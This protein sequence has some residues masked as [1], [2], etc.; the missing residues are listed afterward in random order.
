MAN[1]VK[2]KSPALPIPPAQ[3]NQS[4]YQRTFSILRLYFNQLDEHLRQ[5]LGDTTINGDLTV[6]ADLA[7]IVS[8]D[9]GAAAAPVF[10]LYRNSASP[11]VSDILGSLNFTGNLVS[12]GAKVTYASIDA[13][14]SASLGSNQPK[15]TLR[16][17]TYVNGSQVTLAQLDTQTGLDLGTK[18]L[19]AGYFTIGSDSGYAPNNVINGGLTINNFGSSDNLELVDT[20]PSNVTSDP[21]LSFYRD[22]SSPA[23]NDHAGRIE[24]YANNDA[25]Q[26]TN[27]AGIL[28]RILDVT[29][30]TEDGELSFGVMQAGTFN[31]LLTLDP[32]GVTATGATTVNGALTV[33]ADLLK[34]VSTDAGA[35]ENPILSLYRNSSSIAVS[36]EI[37]AVEFRGNDAEGAEFV[38]G[39][40]YSELSVVG[41]GSEQ[42]NL[43]FALGRAGDIEDPVM[44]LRQYA[45]EMQAGNDIYLSRTS[46]I[47]FEGD[48]T[49]SNET[50][51]YVVDPTADRTILLPDADGTVALTTAPTFT[52]A[53]T[54]NGAFTANNIYSQF[55]SDAMTNYRNGPIVELFANS[56]NTTTSGGA[57][58][59]TGLNEDNRKVSYGSFYMSRSSKLD[60]GEHRGSLVFTVADGS[61]AVDPYDDY[62]NNSFDTGHALALNINVDY[63]ITTGYLKSNVGEL[64]LGDKQSIFDS[65]DV[66]NDQSPYD[67]HMPNAYR[68]KVISIG[69]MGPFDAFVGANQSV[70]QMLQYRGQHMVVA[71]GGA[72]EFELPACAA[73]STISNSTANIGDVWQITNA[74][75]GALTIDRDGSGTAQT[76]Y[77]FPSLTLTAFTN[78]PTLAVGGTMM[79][80]AVAANVW[81][82]FN[83]T[84]LSDA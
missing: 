81:M 70:A 16:F 11:A 72:L 74:A 24:F 27:T 57:F 13:D 52:G 8:T 46:D 71:A 22:S 49:N 1:N 53:T 41:S 4:L 65:A 68:A 23:D 12:G 79:L 34:V 29:D 10:E 31:T 32:N 60:D 33:N 59:F 61:G 30:G 56:T 50:H 19:E 84:G 44:V 77:Y 51:L 80:Q 2:F 28:H 64:K 15:S 78:N 67:L 63:L 25:D 39:R 36:D 14:I 47:I 9:A 26:K 58:V 3:Y 6:N 35:V 40:I 45:L 76:V 55:T 82:I 83:P 62:T 20:V 69:G 43:R 37:G 73:S 38:Y 75:G 5:D 48:T 21:R 18:G 42:A 54:V 7:S 17:N 66:Y